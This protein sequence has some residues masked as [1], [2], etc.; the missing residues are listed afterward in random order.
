MQEF[1]TTYQEPIRFLITLLGTFVIAFV[2]KRIYNRFVLRSSLVLNNDPTNY[3]FLKHFILGLVYI[4][5]ISIAIYQV[6]YF[7][8]IAQSILATAGILAI[9]IGFASQQALANIVSGIFIIL[10]KPFRVNDRVVLKD[11]MVGT[12]E[13]ITL[14]HT[15]IRSFENKRFVIPN[16]VISNEVLTNFDLNDERICRLIEFG[17]SYDSDI[18]KA[19]N[20]IFEECKPH[21]LRIDPRKE[22]D[23]LAGKE[24]I[25]VKVMS[26]GDF[27]VNIR[28]WV[29]ASTWEDSF[30]MEKELIESIK[31]RFDREG[32]EIPFPY[33]TIVFK[34]KNK[35]KSD[36]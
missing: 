21:P 5:G 18:D 30:N 20:I 26:L 12:I 2:F 34:D 4:L 3:K 11:T 27:S 13:D 9:V 29:W 14:R 23:I 31:K 28:A 10:F 22:E 6:S 1:I 33:R 25:P 32:I 8:T 36:D 17:I 19:K 7:K 35:F 24:E 15:V 16:S